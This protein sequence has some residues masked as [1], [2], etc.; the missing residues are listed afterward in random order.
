MNELITEGAGKFG[1]IPPGLLKA[2]GLQPAPS[3]STS[4]VSTS[5]SDVFPEGANVSG[6]TTPAIVATTTPATIATSTPAETATTTPSGTILATPAEPIGQTGATTVPAIPATPLAN[7]ATSTPPADTTAPV[8][9]NVQT[10]NI[11]SS[12]ATIT[13]TTDESSDGTVEYGLTTSY[14]GIVASSSLA[15][16]RSV[17]VSGLQSNTTYHYRVI[18]KDAAG[19]T[20][21]SGDQTFITL[22]PPKQCS[23]GIDNDGDNLIDLND[24]G[25][26][27]STDD[28][29][30]NPVSTGQPQFLLSWGSK[31]S[32]DGQF[33]YAGDIAIDASGNMYVT[34]I[35]NHRI[36][37]F[38]PAQSTF[39][40]AT[41]HSLASVLHSLAA[42]LDEIERQGQ[43]LLAR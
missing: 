41:S 17:T 21:T 8:I 14:G 36:Q 13:W 35:N 16:S 1:I 18:S 30:T 33:A 27:D 39:F 11:T 15:T 28:D 9:S 32:G 23:D 19:N 4:D 43:R 12:A 25:C 3:S 42:A 7:T 37:K 22:A 10:T 38:A 26:T 29:E 20:M 24:S 2:P 6:T 31:G 40:N 34:D 5:T